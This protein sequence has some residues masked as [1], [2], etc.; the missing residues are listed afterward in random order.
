MTVWKACNKRWR[1]SLRAPWLIVGF[2]A[3]TLLLALPLAITLRGLLAAHH[4]D[5]RAAR[6][7]GSGV[8][9]DWWN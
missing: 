5:T 7:A 6:P 4:G 8:N 9:I 1:R 3:L 2:W